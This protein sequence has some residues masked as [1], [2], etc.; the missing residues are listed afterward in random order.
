MRLFTKTLMRLTAAV[1]AAVLSACF[2]GGLIVSAIISARDQMGVNFG[3]ILV[4]LASPFVV[5]TGA[6]LA[7]RSTKH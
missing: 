5:T 7:V 3:M 6:W 4:M 1:V 2:W